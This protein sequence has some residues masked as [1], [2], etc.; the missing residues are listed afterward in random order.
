[1]KIKRLA[2][3]LFALLMLCSVVSIASADSNEKYFGYANNYYTLA[4]GK[5]ASFLLL[6]NSHS[7]YTSDGSC[8]ED[9]IYDCEGPVTATVNS[10][11]NWITVTNTMNSFIV[12]FSPNET[13]KSRT[14]KITVKGDGYKAVMK[15]TQYGKDRILSVKRSKK[16]V[17][18]KLKLSSG[19]KAHYLSVY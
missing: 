18:L 16:T 11:K 8:Y 3:L 6:Y 14:G 1:M 2:A 7:L 17:T 4:K 9:V 13:L 5:T 15:F 10:G 12:T 19:A